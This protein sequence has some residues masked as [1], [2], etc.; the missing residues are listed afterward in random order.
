MKINCFIDST[1]ETQGPR[2]LDLDL[3]PDDNI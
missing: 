1:V 2:N 3:F